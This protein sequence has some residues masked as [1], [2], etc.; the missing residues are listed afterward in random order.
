MPK[1]PFGGHLEDA[2]SN[3]LPN[4]KLDRTT[5]CRSCNGYRLIGGTQLYVPIKSALGRAMIQTPT[6]ISPTDWAPRGNDA[7]LAL[8][9][10]RMLEGSSRAPSPPICRSS[11]RRPS[12]W[13]STSRPQ[14]RSGS[15]FHPLT[16]LAPTTL[17]YLQLLFPVEPSEALLVHPTALAGQQPMQS[18]VAEA[19]PLGGELPNA[20]PSSGVACTTQR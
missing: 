14:R 3:L 8:F 4:E 18:T 20:E 17:A 19:T 1:C 6:P 9:L 12:S 13:S 5:R 11:K 16:P 10:Q 2:R 15:R 7:V